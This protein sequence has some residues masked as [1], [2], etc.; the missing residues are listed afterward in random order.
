MGRVMTIWK[1]CVFQARLSGPL[2][3]VANEDI[4]FFTERDLEPRVLPWQH[5]SRCD[6]VSF[7]MYIAGAMFEEHRLNISRVNLD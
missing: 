1:L 5:H 3:K 6:S 4:W 7:V 2:L